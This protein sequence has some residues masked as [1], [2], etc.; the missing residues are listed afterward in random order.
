M[1]PQA[2][3]PAVASE[4]WGSHTDSVRKV[5][6]NGE[7]KNVDGTP[8]REQAKATEGGGAEPLSAQ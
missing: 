7:A 1:P 8:A 3:L 6:F 5:P 2:C 4:K